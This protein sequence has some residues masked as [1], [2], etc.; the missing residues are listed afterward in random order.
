[1]NL[2]LIRYNQTVSSDFEMPIFDDFFL[3]LQNKI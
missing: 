2:T 1:M 3:F